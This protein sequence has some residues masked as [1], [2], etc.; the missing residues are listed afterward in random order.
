VKIFIFLGVALAGVGVAQ[1]QTVSAAKA[2]GAR[3]EIIDVSMSPGGDRVA[4]LAATGGRGST[5][6]VIDM[7]GD[8][9]P[10]PVVTASGDPEQIAG[11]NW[12]SE[13]RL[14]CNAYTVQRDGDRIIGVT[15]LFAVNSDGSGMKRVSIRQGQTAQ[16]RA[17]F[18][19]AIIDLLPGDDGAV[20]VGRQYVPEGEIGSRLEKRAEGYG[21]DRIDTATLA[22]RR[23]VS[24]MYNAS[25]YISDGR[26]TV[27]IMGAQ[28]SGAGGY[29]E[30]KTRY[31][32]RLIGKDG[33]V[34]LSEYD[35]NTEAGFNPY[36]VD[37]AQ[38]AA[39]GFDRIDGRQA[40]FKVALD[41]TLA[42]TLV[43]SRPDV[44][45]DGIVRIGRQRRVVGVT[46]ATEKRH[47]EYFDPGLLKLARQLGA[48]L[49]KSGFIGFIDTNTD[50]SKM[51]IWS[52]SDID[53]GRYYWLDRKNGRME[54]LFP[55]RPG[56]ADYRL[57][58][59]KPVT[60]RAS[61]GAM[62]PG[63]LTIP[64]GSS[65][66]KLPAI[67]MPHGG[68]SA[69]DE[70]GFDWLAQFYAHQ[71]Y[72]VLQPNYRGSSGYGDGWFRNMGFKAWNV[73][74]GDVNDA[75]RWLVSEGI[76][77]SSKLAIVGW[78]YGGYAALQ[79]GVVAPDLFKAIVAIAP[80]TD[81][82]ALKLSSR[83]QWDYRAAEKFIGSGPHITEGSP[84]Q[85]AAA[86]KAPVLMFHG[87]LDQNVSILQSRMMKDRLRDARKPVELVEFPGL[88]HSL[89]D[90][91]AREAMLAQ[92]D[93]F[94]RAAM[95]M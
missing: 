47:V 58:E 78:S 66:K 74:I 17:A 3:T 20:L 86:I 48:A 1:A 9:K 12:V 75:G 77:D 23:V 88:T 79:S 90:N 71:G 54:E 59:V 28:F 2:F 52:G 55:E 22:T 40:L 51:V 87:D 30:T 16:Y 24:P 92:S 42:R 11:C 69:R 72:A 44:D 68:P 10:R 56:L 83:D 21:V 46:Y 32:Y 89:N 39:Y 26:G 93:A 35:W 85:N 63:Y 62:V 13:S 41:G 50:E 94:L 5:L 57:A 91:R 8:A 15:K 43:F 31:S 25:E 29:A 6:Y 95:G 37:P 64:P 76:A 81:L 38:N 53:P 33:W 70:W 18:G 34:P 61:D 84:A 45:V 65:G 4:Y 7:A 19:G 80:V 73:A 67:V 49:P 60:F 36:A 27:R 14:I 82:A